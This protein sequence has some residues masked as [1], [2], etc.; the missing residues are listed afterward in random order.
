MQGLATR[1]G[2]PPAA[3]PRVL[4]VADDAVSLL[5]TE[6]VPPGKR[7]RG[8]IVAMRAVVGT[9]CDEQ[10]AAGAGTIDNIDGN[11]FEVMHSK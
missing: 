7:P 11:V 4:K 5:R 6:L 1:Q 3:H 10:G 9:A 8:L 2:Q